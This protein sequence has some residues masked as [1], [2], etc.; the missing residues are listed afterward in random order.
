MSDIDIVTKIISIFAEI[1]FNGMNNTLQIKLLHITSNGILITSLE[2]SINL[3]MKF[4]SYIG[5]QT[6]VST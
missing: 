3:L 1:I 2:Y 6:G 4:A 5:S